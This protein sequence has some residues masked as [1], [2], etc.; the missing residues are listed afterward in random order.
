M[1]Q[2][3]YVMKQAVFVLTA[4]ALCVMGMGAFRSTPLL[5]QQPRTITVPTLPYKLVPDFLKYELNLGEVLGVAVNSKGQIVVMHHPGSATTGP[6]YGNA[7]TQILEFDSTGK[8]VREI[9]KGVYGLAYAHS[10]RFDKYDNLWVVDKGTNSVMKF[11]PAGYVTMN[12]G[13]RPEG[14]D[15]PADNYHRGSRGEPPVHRDGYFG[16]PTDVAWDANDNIYISDGY[17]NSRV[18]K[19]D[20]NGNWLKSWGTR[21]REPGQ[22]NIPHNLVVDRQG[23]V[24]VADRSNRRI[25]VF[26]GE[27]NL[28]GNYKL[29]AA[30]DKN[31]QPTLG[32]KLK[33]PP[34]D[35][36]AGVLC[37]TDGP[38]QYLFASDMLPGRVYKLALDGTILGTFGES[39]RQ[40]GQ[41]NWVHA[42]SCRTES[43]VYVADMNNWRLQKFV[44]QP[45][46]TSR[47]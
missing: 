4:I 33:E 25:Q 22:L 12:L 18:A 10:V 42:L 34:D 3:R 23:T 28:K 39:G 11:N 36:D 7:S 45:E 24:Y 38:T 19:L 26:D 31:M 14:P 47:Q 35:G 43:T 44:L 46:R 40:P 21:G 5:A 29:N 9:G 2:E 32:N 41:F 30:Y 1:K 17:V 13:R 8:F 37:I 16:G 6:V 15:D 20:K 27:G